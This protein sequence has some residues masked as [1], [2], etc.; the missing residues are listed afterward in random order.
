MDVE[1]CRI[2]LKQF[3]NAREF[4]SSLCFL[5]MQFLHYSCFMQGSFFLPFHFIALTTIDLSTSR[6]A[7]GLPF[8]TGIC[9]NQ[10]REN[11]KIW[12]RNAAHMHCRHILQCAFHCLESRSNQEAK[13]WLKVSERGIKC[14]E[15]HLI[16]NK[17]QATNRCQCQMKSMPMPIFLRCVF[18]AF[19]YRKVSHQQHEKSINQCL[20]MQG[21]E[22]VKKK[23]PLHKTQKMQ[24]L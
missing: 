21:N 23:E 16:S 9:T 7:D 20:L 19:L 2:L 1:C 3:D 11:Q 10:N 18:L 17:T 13:Q 14:F 6:V 22:T 24:K 4:D 12:I 5:F 8:D 15:V